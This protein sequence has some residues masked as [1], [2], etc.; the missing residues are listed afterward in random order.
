MHRLHVCHVSVTDGK[1]K[2]K[3]KHCR[4]VFIIIAC[5][6]KGCLY[7]HVVVSTVEEGV[8]FPREDAQYNT[9]VSERPTKSPSIVR[10]ISHNLDLAHSVHLTV[11]HSLPRPMHCD[12]RQRLP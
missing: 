5:S 10:R 1:V 3:I 12:K 2:K 9:Q 8:G 6:N 11:T 4:N 7:R